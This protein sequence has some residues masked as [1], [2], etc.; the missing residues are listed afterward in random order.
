[1]ILEAIIEWFIYSNLA[2]VNMMGQYFEHEGFNPVQLGALM[3]VVPSLALVA[4]PFWFWVK[5]KFGEKKTV[6]IITFIPAV[7]CWGI[8]LLPGFIPKL[9]GLVGY[10]FFATSV[11]PLTE[12][13]VMNSLMNKGIHL[14]RSRMLGT[15]GFSSTALLL[16]FVIGFGYHMMFVVVTV[17]LLAAF[18]FSRRLKLPDK[19]SEKKYRSDENGSIK[20]FVIM[21]ITA[22]LGIM[23][24]SFCGAFLPVLVSDRGYPENVVGI[25]FA[26]LSISEVPFLFFAK[27]I[28]NKM[29]NIFLLTTGIFA[30]ALR[31]LLTPLTVSPLTLVLV[32][33]LH[34]WN[35]I[36]IY[37]SIFNYIHF[38]LKEKHLN[39]AQAT[40][41]MVIQGGGFLSGYLGGG[42]LVDALG[43]YN[44]YY[45]FGTISLLYSI[46][47]FVWSFFDIR[48]RKLR[49]GGH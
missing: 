14:D 9:I 49:A 6:G 16:G 41:W 34:G 32:H 12:A 35:Y 45:T 38:K 17:A 10:G 23:N 28:I 29:G 11:V 21:L 37:Y 47:L 39:K 31:V 18:F 25:S 22:M 27:S 13:G 40:F 2:F 3:A 26:V 15:V 30:V 5:K 43:L 36:V 24:A 44:A 46:P 19:M 42:F 33:I 1:M 7:T 20:V 48:K 8:F 4:N